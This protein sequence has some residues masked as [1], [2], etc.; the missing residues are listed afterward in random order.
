MHT[1]KQARQTLQLA[2]DQDLEPS[3]Y[4]RA[5]EAFP[6]VLVAAKLGKL[7]PLTEFQ[8]LLGLKRPTA[9]L[10]ELVSRGLDGPGLLAAVEAVKRKVWDYAKGILL[11]NGKDPFPAPSP[12]GTRYRLGVIY[13][14]EIEG[15]CTNAAIDAEMS[16][17]GVL[18]CHP[19][20]AFYLREAYSQ[21][22]LL[23]MANANR[24]KDSPEI[25]LVVVRHKT[26]RD[27]RGYAHL[28]GLYRRDGGDGVHADHGDPD[29]E[30]Y[31]DVAFV[32]LPQEDS[33]T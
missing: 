7:P 11:G 20:V 4:T 21:E 8:K 30:W 16:A 24:P 10:C 23:K 2:E 6:A 29:V 27:S 12:K 33:E 3:L 19:E 17:R 1:A 5:L 13:A 25:T 26:L 32:V 22:A 9:F 28:F 15:R 18:N 31:A 14:S